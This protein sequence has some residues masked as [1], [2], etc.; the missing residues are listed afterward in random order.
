MVEEGTSTNSSSPEQRGTGDRSGYCL[1]CRRL[2][3]VVADTVDFLREI[4]RWEDFI[5]K[6][7]TTFAQEIKQCLAEY[8]ASKSALPKKKKN[9]KG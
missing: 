9:S 7:L 3:T 2:V 6:K 5:Q 1:H 8:E 4:Y